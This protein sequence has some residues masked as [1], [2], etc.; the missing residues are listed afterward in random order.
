MA[1]AGASIAGFQEA[2]PG[3]VVKTIK[4]YMVVSSGPN[5]SAGGW[6]AWISKPM[7]Q[8]LD[9]MKQRAS[10]RALLARGYTLNP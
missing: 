9:D 3:A 8:K 7:V 10:H 4:F 2:R 1:E 6:E 5:A